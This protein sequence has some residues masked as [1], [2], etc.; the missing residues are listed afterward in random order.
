MSPITLISRIPKGGG[1]SSGSGGSGYRGGGVVYVN[2]GNGGNLPLWLTLVIIFT[3]L[4]VCIYLILFTIFI[5]K[6]YSQQRKLEPNQRVP[7]LP[8]IGRCAWKAF[9]YA[10][11]IQLVIWAVRKVAGACARSRNGGGDD[12][13]NKGATKKVGGSF[14]HKITKEE[15]EDAK[16]AAAAAAGPSSAPYSPLPAHAN[17]SD[18]R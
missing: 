18:G 3:T 15:E 2:T 5:R 17:S 9:K 1:G 6:E 14:Y 11:L 12:G 10:T 8:L 13:D 16:T 7:K 4:W